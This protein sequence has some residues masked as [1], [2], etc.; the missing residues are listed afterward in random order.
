VTRNS[1]CSNAKLYQSSQNIAE[2][3]SLFKLVDNDSDENHLK[4]VIITVE[5]RS[6]IETKSDSQKTGKSRKESEGYLEI[7][8]SFQAMQKEG[9]DRCEEMQKE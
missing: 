1:N 3:T 7:I 9:I 2:I 5:V 6:N 8:L 4:E